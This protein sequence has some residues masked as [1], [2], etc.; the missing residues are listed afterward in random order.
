[1]KVIRSGERAIR[2]TDFAGVVPASRGAHCR[3]LHPRLAS[4]CFLERKAITDPRAY[5]QPAA[6]PSNRIRQRAPMAHRRPPTGV[7]HR[8]VGSP[9]NHIDTFLFDTIINSWRDFRGGVA[10]I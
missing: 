9:E 7:A 8:G 2:A 3:P 1:M 10:V 6:G 5:P 4:L